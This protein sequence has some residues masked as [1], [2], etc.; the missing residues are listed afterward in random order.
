MAG[1]PRAHLDPREVRPVDGEPC[2]LFLGQ[3]QADGHGVEAAPR[4]D[5]P[6]HALQ[7]VGGEQF[8]LDEARK[9]VL[10]VGGLLADEFELV[11]RAVERER[12]AIAVEDEAAARR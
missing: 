7:V 5:E 4:L 12:L 8:E 3:L 6:A 9:C 11:G 2:Q 1:E 10:H